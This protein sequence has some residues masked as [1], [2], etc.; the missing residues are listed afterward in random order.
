MSE[1]Q[2]V[3]EVV[4][5]STGTPGRSLNRARGHHFVIDEPARSGG[6]GE[7][8]TPAEAFL[9]GVS[10]CG[11]LLVESHAREVGVKLDRV[12]A[13]IA[14]RRAASDPGRFRDVELRFRLTG[15]TREQATELVGHYQSH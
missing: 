15:P 14:G 2:I 9:A 1:E 3:N 5:Y 12:E 10:A 4:S 6:A 13:T 11:V 7:E 8:V